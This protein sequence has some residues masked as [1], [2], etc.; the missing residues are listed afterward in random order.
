MAAS[1]EFFD[2]LQCYKGPSLEINFTLAYPLL[3]LLTSRS[4]NWASQYGI[5]KPS[6]VRISVEMEEQETLMSWMKATLEAAEA[7][8][9]A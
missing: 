3:F 2:T 6:L 9:S 8:K 7:V 5:M 4:W 1:K